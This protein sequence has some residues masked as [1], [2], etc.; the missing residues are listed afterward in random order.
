[1]LLAAATALAVLLAPTVAR[2]HPGGKDA[3]GCHY[4]RKACAMYGLKD[5]EYHCHNDGAGAPPPAAAPAPA[6]PAPA[7]AAPAPPP[8]PAPSATPAPA[9][10]GPALLSVASIPISEVYVDGRL[11]GRAPLADLPLAA[12]RHVVRLVSKRFGVEKTIER[13]VRPGERVTLRLALH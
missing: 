10:N 2:A 12:G 1:M 13:E 7:V 4:C 11:V 6:P 3:K 8:A 5:D 9:S